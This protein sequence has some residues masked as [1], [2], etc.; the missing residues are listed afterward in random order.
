MNPIGK[1]GVDTVTGFKGRVTGRVEYLNSHVDLR[2]EPAVKED[3]SPVEPQWFNE[4]RVSI[5]AEPA[6]LARED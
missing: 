5:I 4:N 3:G 6:G 2:L 1:M